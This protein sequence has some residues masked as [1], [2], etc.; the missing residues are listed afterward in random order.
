[1]AKQ[2]E[3]KTPAPLRKPPTPGNDMQENTKPWLAS[4]LFVSIDKDDLESLL[5]LW[6]KSGDV[7]KKAKNSTE[8]TGMKF[9]DVALAVF[10][11]GLDTL[12]DVLRYKFNT[13][14]VLRDY[15][16]PGPADFL[17]EVDAAIHYKLL[18]AK[19]KGRKNKSG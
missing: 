16:K 5:G 14:D 7:K 12:D 4:S 11:A 19:K 1:M 3:K 13:G 2:K 17:G 8:F 6:I 18:C 10:R 9:S 15:V